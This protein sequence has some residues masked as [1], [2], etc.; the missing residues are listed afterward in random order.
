MRV[1]GLSRIRAGEG[2]DVVVTTQRRKRAEEEEAEDYAWAI[3][4]SHH[5]K[6]DWA[7]K[8]AD[9]IDRYSLTALLRIKRRAWQI[10]ED[11]RA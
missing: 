11:R 3:L 1:L 6:P 9:I 4:N 5:I 10:I 8:N 7:A 2:S